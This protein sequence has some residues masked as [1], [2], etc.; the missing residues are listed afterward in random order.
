MSLLE[1][2]FYRSK[3]D[4]LSDQHTFGVLERKRAVRAIENLLLEEASLTEWNDAS[5]YLTG[6]ASQPDTAQAKADR[7]ERYQLAAAGPMESARES[8]PTKQKQRKY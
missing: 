5:A 8:A 3:S 1:Y 2:L 4:I 7:A 6:Q